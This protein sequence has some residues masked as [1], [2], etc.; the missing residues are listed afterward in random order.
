MT[1]IVQVLSNTWSAESLKW[2]NWN[3]WV[4]IQR[5]L[6]TWH[7][8][9]TTHLQNNYENNFLN[10]SKNKMIMFFFFSSNGWSRVFISF[11]IRPIRAGQSSST[12]SISPVLTPLSGLVA[13][14]ASPHFFSAP[15]P[16]L[17]S[18]Q[19]PAPRREPLGRGQGRPPGP[20]PGLCPQY[21]A[22]T[23]RPGVTRPLCRYTST[24][25]IARV[26]LM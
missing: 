17:G 18:A 14:V 24:L 26:L 25:N 21:S 13:Q 3:W 6:E 19:S 11:R 1:W 5:R 10:S 15:A 12:P 4:D 20:G 8:H 9:M 7:I 2:F 23:F 22:L 16:P